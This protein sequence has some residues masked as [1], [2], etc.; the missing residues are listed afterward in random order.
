MA[1]N[2]LYPHT[3]PLRAR[4][5]FVLTLP[6]S[7]PLLLAIW[8]ILLLLAVPVCSII[9]LAWFAWDAIATLWEPGRG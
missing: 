7:G 4:R 8:I 2:L 1:F 9:A 5:A 6:V 3:W